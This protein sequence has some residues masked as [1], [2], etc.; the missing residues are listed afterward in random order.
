MTLTK[1]TLRQWAE[2]VHIC[3]TKEQE[4]MILDRFGAEPGDGYVWTELDIAEQ[5]R[6]IAGSARNTA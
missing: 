4:K 3:L 1:K 6:K 2:S 5:I